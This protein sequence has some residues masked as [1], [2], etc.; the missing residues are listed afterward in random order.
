MDYDKTIR[1]DFLQKIKISQN[2]PI[3]NQPY[4]FR[5]RQNKSLSELPRLLFIHTIRPSFLRGRKQIQIHQLTS[6]LK[7]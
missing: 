3:G 6:L 7:K 4:I 2:F 1:V 5:N